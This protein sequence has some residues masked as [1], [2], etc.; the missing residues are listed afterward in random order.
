M[1]CGEAIAIIKAARR[2]WAYAGIAAKSLRQ[3]NSGKHGS[4]RNM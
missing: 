1:L 3:A 2:G 4:K